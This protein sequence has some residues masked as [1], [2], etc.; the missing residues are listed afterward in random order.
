MIRR[1]RTTT[2]DGAPRR[3]NGANDTV[4]RYE[5]V[6][7]RKSHNGIAVNILVCS[8]KDRSMIQGMF[9]FMILSM[10]LMRSVNRSCCSVSA[11][12]WYSICDDF[13]SRQRLYS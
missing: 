5:W 10:A 4:M 11:L 7:G 3:M 9:Y 12:T 1:V 13:G 8:Y 2:L 6:Q